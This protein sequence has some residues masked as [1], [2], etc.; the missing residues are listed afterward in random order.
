M[1]AVGFNPRVAWSPSPCVAERR[2]NGSFGGFRCRS[3]A[4]YASGLSGHRGLKPTA[5]LKP[6]LRD[7]P[8]QLGTLG[9]LAGRRARSAQSSQ[10]APASQS[11]SG[12]PNTSRTSNAPPPGS[13][14]YLPRRVMAE[15]YAGW[16]S[17]QIPPGASKVAKRT[18]HQDCQSAIKRDAPCLRAAKRAAN[19]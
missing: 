18:L 3:P 16:F 6:S 9:H 14:R 1:V 2:F 4:P 10:P 8:S 15:V 12:N 5:T 13:R 11:R 19:R 7:G 17:S